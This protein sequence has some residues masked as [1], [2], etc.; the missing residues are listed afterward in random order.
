M[1]FVKKQM[2]IYNNTNNG[3][4]KADVK[5]MEKIVGRIGELEKK[6]NNN[7]A[8]TRVKLIFSET[9]LEGLLPRKMKMLPQV[10]GKP[11]YREVELTKTVLG[12]IQKH[13]K[14]EETRR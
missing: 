5:K 13:L 9:D 4:S 3:M 14:N 12:S 11:G 2:E 8:D 1:R 6:A 10:P 7:I